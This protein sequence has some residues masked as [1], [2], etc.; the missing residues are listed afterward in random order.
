MCSCF[1]RAHK[2]DK[3]RFQQYGL[4]IRANECSN[5]SRNDPVDAIGREV[6]AS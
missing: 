6:S 2:S 3:T 5:T 4:E 1:P